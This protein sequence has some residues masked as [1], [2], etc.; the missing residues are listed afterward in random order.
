VIVRVV[1]EGRKPSGFTNFT[2]YRRAC[3]LP[4]QLSELSFTTFWTFLYEFSFFCF[5]FWSAVVIIE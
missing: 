4:L 3:A 1:A 5:D 2:K